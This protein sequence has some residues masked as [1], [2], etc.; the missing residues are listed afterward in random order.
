MKKKS[1][2]FLFLFFTLSLFAQSDKAKFSARIVDGQTG[3]PLP[4][5][6]VY[7]AAGRG[8]LSNLDGNFTI[9][10]EAKDSLYFTIMGYEPQRFRADRLPEV[11]KMT[12]RVR[13][14]DEVTVLGTEG[15]LSKVQKK[16]EK[17]YKKRR[18]RS[19]YYFNRISV[20]YGQQ[21]EMVEDFIEARSAVNLR[22]LKVISG[23]YWNSDLQLQPV[24][25]DAIH[26]PSY[27]VR[28]NLHKMM[29]LGPMV[30]DE[31]F[32]SWL[33][34]PLPPRRSPKHWDKNYRITKETLSDDD[35]R[36]VYRIEMQRKDLKTFAVLSGTLYVDAATCRLLRFDGT[37][38]NLVMYMKL[39][40]LS[41]AYIPT[42]FSLHVDY[43]HD[44][45]FTEV[46]NIT[47]RIV[48][49]DVEVNTTMV[50]VDDYNLPMSWGVAIKNNILRTINEAGYNAELSKQ[51]DF[52]QRTEDEETLVS[53]Q[54]Q[55][56]TE[57][58]P[59]LAS[60]SSLTV[61]LAQSVLHEKD[62][63]LAL[64]EES[65]K[66][67]S[68]MKHAMRFSLVQPAEK[69][70]LHIDNTGYFEGETIWFKAYVIRTDTEARTDL[71][72]ILYVELLNPTGEVVERR[73]LPIVNGMAYGDIKLDSLMVTGFYEL[74]AFTRYLTNWGTYA[75][76]SR[77]LPVF[78]T[79]KQ[80]GDYS[81]PQ[82]DQL[83][84][85]HRLPDVRTEEGDPIK[86]LTPNPS[87]D[88]LRPSGTSPSMGR[89]IRMVSPS[90]EGGVGGGSS[91]H[92]GG[93]VR[94][95]EGVCFYPEGGNLIAGLTGRVAFTLADKDGQPLEAD[96]EVRDA[97]DNVII[98]TTTQTDGIGQ[99]TFQPHANTQYQL[100]V[101]HDEKVRRINLPAVQP[102]GCSLT[103]NMLRSD[104]ITADIQT[105][106]ALHGK[107]LG[108]VLMHGGRILLC[109]TL[110]AAPSQRL[111]FCRRAMPA[112]VSQLTLFDSDGNICAD[113]LLFV[114]PPPSPADSIRIMAPTDYIRP[115][116]KVELTLWTTP[117][118]TLSF[119]ATDAATTL[120]HRPADIR[121][122][123]L[124][125][126]EVRGYIH[127]PE[128]YFEADDSLHRL[129]ADQLMMVQGWRRYSVA[130]PLR[131]YGHLP[132]N[133]EEAIRMVSP[134][135]YG[136]GGG[137]E[138]PLFSPE[139]RQLIQGKI[140][141]KKKKK[142]LPSDI[143]LKAILYNDQGQVLAGADTTADSLGQ[144][145]FG[146]PEVVG[147][148]KLQ[149]YTQKDSLPV[150]CRVGIDRYFSP[151]PR[152]LFPQECQTHPVDTTAIFHWQTD[153]AEPPV[154]MTS[155]DH[156]LDEV[157]VKAQ[158]RW[159]GVE[160]WANEHDARRCSH[161][162]YNCDDAVDRLIDE[163]QPIPS[164]C[165]WLKQ[166]NSFFAGNNVPGHTI[167]IY[168]N[169]DY[170]TKH[171][172]QLYEEFD[173]FYEKGY[174]IAPRGEDLL[175]YDD[176]LTY[177][178]RPL[179]WI[180]DNTFYTVTNYHLTRSSREPVFLTN[181]HTNTMIDLP[182]ELEWVKSVY[183]SE[184][185]EALHRHIH[186]EA[187]DQMNPVVLYVYTH[188]TLAG[189][190]KGLRSTYYQGYDSPST[191]QM[192]D[193]S[194][195]PPM[196]DFRRTLYWNPTLTADRYGKVNISFYNNSSCTDMF[197]SVEGMSA[198]GRRTLSALWAPPP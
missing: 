167:I 81:H 187:I 148:W 93:D 134:P 19:S 47:F 80:E 3:E 1:V 77:V 126:S 32:W 108:Y 18:R 8:V 164:F 105:T 184:D 198:D 156:L 170:P 104:S 90:I 35:G 177:K 146:L 51:Y 33:T 100:I 84:H 132:H 14:L 130:D 57:E 70:Y 111:A 16:L 143:S 118:A 71:S 133:G 65:R 38:S 195:L 9:E 29:S 59:V 165:E 155:K 91:P 120:T 88:P 34:T 116:G 115:C 182:V 112:G 17:D 83:S 173:P 103:L 181:D 48:S 40:D 7:I 45:G 157:T 39:A 25:T 194:V 192:P 26:Y 21:R 122:W 42:D 166:R 142:K 190:P 191:F 168:P 54:N 79:P 41:E 161:I 153:G 72:H 140:Y 188:R 20:T 196:E 151:P 85:R 60:D 144:Y 76:F 55:T 10:A 99:F 152:T 50:N 123:M 149:I 56:E 119:S 139:K 68:Y 154:L 11:V 96:C 62:T 89:A 135:H 27:W 73:K 147:T 92:R 106:T 46:D 82:I 58:P 37:V 183:I 158:K 102:E 109:D 117:R 61:L 87:T 162:Y 64:S 138:G 67:L 86:T 172:A 2:L 124:L 74:R 185:L 169:P 193:Y 159:T 176:G 24:G 4:C 94:R 95:T 107:M 13:S 22:E 15:L 171:I 44:R 178:N 128:Q 63:L 186:C 150:D 30:Q 113:R 174:D 78:K 6:H 43:R 180:I 160:P 127:H 179:V 189:Q 5:V 52:V 98:H 110:L 12:E 53:G 136:G 97:K 137:G 129:A 28:S 36:L 23:Q 163:G 145:T 121:S 49:E 101:H 175:V 197:I 69:V 125:A 75:C 66:V 131:P 114:C 141:P 31:D